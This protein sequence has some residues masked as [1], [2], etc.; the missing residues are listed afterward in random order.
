MKTSCICMHGV[1]ACEDAMNES[2]VFEGGIKGLLCVI[3]THWNACN[4]E[5]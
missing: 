5:K 4:V 1:F 3:F 2:T